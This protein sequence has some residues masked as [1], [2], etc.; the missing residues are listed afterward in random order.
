MLRSLT[1]AKRVATVTFL[2][3]SEKSD[4]ISLNPLAK[5][6][7]TVTFLKLSEKSDVFPLNPLAK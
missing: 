7:A 1:P 3:L 4:V 2:K 6:V 5:R